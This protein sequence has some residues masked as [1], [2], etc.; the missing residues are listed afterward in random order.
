MEYRYDEGGF[1]KIITLVNY[2]LQLILKG[3]GTTE[4]GNY[5]MYPYNDICCSI[6]VINEWR[7]C[8]F[9]DR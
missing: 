7:L 4:R 2:A 1:G 3:K 8:R 5:E 6:H 9:H